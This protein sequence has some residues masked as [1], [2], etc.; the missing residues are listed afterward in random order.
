MN[1]HEINTVVKFMNLNNFLGVFAVDELDI[2]TNQS[3]GLLVFNTDT[4]EKNGQH[5]ISICLTNDKLIY[6]DSLM[7]DFY[8]SDHLKNLVSR[9]GKDL[10]INRIQ[11]QSELSDKCGFH[12]LVFC[13]IMSGKGS[14]NRFKSFL[15][16]FHPLKLHQRE[17]LSL[18]YF[19][20][21]VR[22]G[23]WESF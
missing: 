21:L 8:K 20:I 1:S 17:N 10:I 6:Y 3:E 13:M 5:W 19:N 7:I 18:E 11:T 23:G 4:S 16:S 15:E 2:I 22:H 9:L 12:C 14:V